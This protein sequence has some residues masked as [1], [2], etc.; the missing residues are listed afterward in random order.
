MHSNVCFLDSGRTS[1]ERTL[2]VASCLKTGPVVGIAVTTF[3]LG[4]VVTAVIL[5]SVIR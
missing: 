4:C 1:T 2:P 5:L 3:L